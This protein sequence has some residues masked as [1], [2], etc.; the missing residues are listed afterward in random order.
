MRTSSSRASGRPRS[1]ATARSQRGAR[2][3]SAR[4][5]GEVRVRRA[6]LCRPSDD[7]RRALAR[8]AYRPERTAAR[9]VLPRRS[10]YR[11]H[12]ASGARTLFVATLMAVAM[13]LRS[14]EREGVE[15]RGT[16]PSHARLA[17]REP[18]G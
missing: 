10:A 12:L 16:H 2:N 3:G 8:S 5:G 14:V 7:V 6:L 15:E 9:L 18:S 4:C 17:G 11:E 1:R 13:E